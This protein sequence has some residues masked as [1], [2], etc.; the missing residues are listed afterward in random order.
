M[1]AAAVSTDLVKL[2]TDFTVLR[3]RVAGELTGARFLWTSGQVMTDGWLPWDV[4]VINVAPSI[5]A[6]K[7]NTTGI[8]IKVPGLYQ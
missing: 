5:I 7:K 3:N 1:D 8:T 6:W 2:E 4:Q